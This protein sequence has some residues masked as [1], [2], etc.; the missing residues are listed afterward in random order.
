MLRQLV[1]R[2]QFW[3]GVQKSVGL[4]RLCQ[5]RSYRIAAPLPVPRQQQQ[6]A[7][8]R[9]RNYA[10]STNAA[11]T[12]IPQCPT[13]GAAFQTEAPG[14]PGYLNQQKWKLMNQANLVQGIPA[15][16]NSQTQNEESQL[17]PALQQQA[18]IKDHELSEEEY[19]RAVESIDDPEIRAL[20]EGEP[21][22][23]FEGVTNAPAVVANETEVEGDLDTQD[24]AAAHDSL[25]AAR[26]RKRVEQGR[27]RIVC[28]RCHTLKHYSCIDHPWKND[29]VT[30][31]RSLKFLRYRTNLMVVVVCDLFDIPSSMIPNLGEFIGERH[32]VIVVANKADLLPR[33]YHEERLKMWLRRFVKDLGLNVQAIHLVSALKNLG[34]RDLAAD[35]TERRRAGQDIY[36]VG[37]ANVGKS[38]VLNALLRI[39]IGGSKHRVLASHVPGTTMGLSGIPLRH[40]VRALVPDEGARPQDRQACLYDTPGVFSSKSVISFLTNEELRL[41]MCSKRIAPFSFILNLNQSILLGGLGRIDLVDGPDRV[42]A[43]VFSAVRPHFTNTRRAAELVGKLEDGQRTILQPP[44]GDAERLKSFPK[45]RLAVEHT[46][47][48]LHKKHATLDVVFAGIGWIAITGQFPQATIRV[49]SPNGCGVYVRPPMMPFEYKKISPHMSNMRKTPK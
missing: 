16:E 21:T 4:A 2:D 3:V 31:P 38:E 35:I 18:P 27:D 43:T 15:I 11:K 46:F 17:P 14:A 29:V 7:P 48:G 26:H 12:K 10:I 45:Q 41:A 49:Y 22:A 20:F 1:R 23:G 44:A 24:S 28:Q 19:K 9:R 47:E 8:Y 6:V 42:Y 36:M 25:V 13:C 32:S 37:R 5:P 34:I 39:S 33:D 30:D 40:F